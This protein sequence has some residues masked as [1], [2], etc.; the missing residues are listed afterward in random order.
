MDGSPNLR[1]GDSF[2]NVRLTAEVTLAPSGE[3]V[4]LSWPSGHGDTTSR[5][6]FWGDRDD[7][8]LV[9]LD[10]AAIAEDA[11]I[12]DSTRE[13]HYRLW[14]SVD[15]WSE[16]K[17]ESLA[18]SAE[19][20]S[21]PGWS[22]RWFRIAVDFTASDTRIWIDGRMIWSQPESP[23]R[24][25][26]LNIVLPKGADKRRLL[27]F[28][29]PGKRFLP[30]DLSSYYNSDAL[31][32]GDLGDGFAFADDLLQGHGMANISE[33][34]FYFEWMQ[35]QNNNC[36]LGMTDCRGYLPYIQCDALS[37]D[38]KRVLLRVPKRYYD[39]AHL[40]CVADKQ[41]NEIPSAAIRMIKTGR[42]H[43]TTAMYD[44]PY[45][46]DENSKAI[47]LD[48]GSMDSRMNDRKV[49]GRM[50]L[51]SVPLNPSDF[52]D[53]LA[54]EDETFLELDLTR[55]IGLDSQRYPRPM[56]PPSSVH[57]FALTLE[58]APVSM[59]VTSD[60][61]GHIFE[62]PQQPVMHVKL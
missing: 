9:H 40:V 52:Q 22:K 55:L 31:K 45:W 7:N 6:R 29:L 61:I 49:S 25:N 23:G 44:V 46:D 10:L 5:L 3:P 43:E 54:A 53:F 36:D 56:G 42:G 19:F 27:S 60:T 48:C 57:L 51:L 30:L 47:P 14:P 11:V 20:Q 50:W 59:V 38:P 13:E 2:D 15:G 39:R 35:G 17:E 16:K 12:S 8:G 18:Y 58:E 28:S 34:P 32:G 33:I 41:E 62:D 21:L 26:Q 1:E 37:S 4:T 24:G